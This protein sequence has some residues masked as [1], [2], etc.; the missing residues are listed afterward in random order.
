MAENFIYNPSQ[1]IAGAFEQANTS[2]GNAFATVLARKQHDY[3]V[4]DH[5]FQNLEA[6]KK[7]VNLFGRE[8]VKG[9]ISQTMGEMSSDC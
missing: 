9:M 6:L 7:D 8:E 2:L 5:I 3:D 1:K 4:A